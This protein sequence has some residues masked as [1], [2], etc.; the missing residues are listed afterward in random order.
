MHA[1]DGFIPNAKSTS[2][3]IP[4]NIIRES[5]IYLF[6][7]PVFFCDCYYLYIPAILWFSV[8]GCVIAIGGILWC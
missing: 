2:T 8:S 6:C 1:P 7:F 4:Y 3:F 5:F